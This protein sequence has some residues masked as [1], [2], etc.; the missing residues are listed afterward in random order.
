MLRMSRL[1]CATENMT[2]VQVERW[3]D[4]VESPA[5]VCA[6]FDFNQ[7]SDLDLVASGCH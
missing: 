2:Q 3:D 1:F 4:V 7:L 6:G 5:W